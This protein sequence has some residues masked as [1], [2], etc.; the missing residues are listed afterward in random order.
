[1]DKLE[2]I[3]LSQVERTVVQGNRRVQ[4]SLTLPHRIHT[5]SHI[6]IGGTP[7]IKLGQLVVSG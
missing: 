1:M 6:A 5:L 4:I 7:N 2:V 3:L